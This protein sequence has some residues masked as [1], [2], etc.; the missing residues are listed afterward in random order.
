MPNPMLLAPVAGDDPCGRDLRW[1]TEFT[2]LMDMLAAAAADD[3]SVLDAEVA[4]ADMLTFDEVVEAAVRLSART[5]DV[6]VLAVHAEA[7]WRHGGLAAFADAME[8]LAAVLETWPGPADGVHPRGDEDDGDLGERVAA[9]GRLLKLIPTLAATVGWHAETSAR[10]KVESSATLKGVFGRW[11]DRLEA[12]FGADLPSPTEAWRSLQ[13]IVVDP[14]PSADVSG[15]EDAGMSGEGTAA[16][17]VLDVWDLIDR[18]VEEM[19]RQD[20]H[21]PAL[22]VLRLLASWRSL[23]ILDIVDAM[24]SSG[25]TLEQLLE[26]VKKQTRQ[27]S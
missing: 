27:T 4:R 24:K 7:S 8:D 17:P 14:A 3:G 6:R 1:D 11:R 12:A 13:G 21:S 16:A 22:P 15:G 20:H 25:V 19:D 23:D 2:G 5:K 10:Q 18:A 9:L 26:S